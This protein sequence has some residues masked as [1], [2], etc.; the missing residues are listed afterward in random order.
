MAIRLVSQR[1]ISNYFVAVTKEDANYWQKAVNFLPADKTD[2]FIE[3]TQPLVLP[4]DV[5]RSSA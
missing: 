4:S 3:R 1:E 5:N 2:H